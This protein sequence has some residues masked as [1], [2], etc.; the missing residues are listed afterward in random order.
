MVQAIMD[1]DYTNH[2]IEYQRAQFDRNAYTLG[3]IGRHN[4]VLVYMPGM[5]NTN[6][7]SVAADL[8]SSFQAIEIVFVVGICG[9]VSTNPE[10]KDELV[11]GDCIISTSVAQYD[12]ARLFPKGFEPKTG[13]DDILG[14]ASPLIRALIAKLKTNTNR[15]R[16]TRQLV[17][18]LCDLQT[19]RHGLAYPGAAQD[20]L[21]DS[22]YIHQ[23]HDSD[24]RCSECN[25]DMDTCKRDCEALGCD[26]IYLINRARL[27]GS[28]PSLLH[29]RIHFGTF[30][31]SNTLM[32]SG[33]D[34]DN[35]SEH[36]GIIAFEM[37]SAGIWDTFPTIIIK[38]GCDYADSH[39][40]KTWQNYA[41]ASAACMLKV[42]LHQLETWQDSPLPTNNIHF[43]VDN[44][45][46]EQQH[47][48]GMRGLKRMKYPGRSRT[49]DRSGRVASEGFPKSQVT[50]DPSGVSAY[51]MYMQRSMMDASRNLGKAKV[52]IEPRG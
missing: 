32:R 41:A 45:W 47:P 9:I 18:L 4:V 1:E 6:S 49:H 13:R 12:N 42:F 44:P 40:N 50:Q 48:F 16:L 36:S 23:H 22:T 37:E 21:F 52:L 30:G 35:L 19:K 24:L 33:L 46:V 10:T 38:A 51:D 29:P 39:K 34:R 3:L 25:Q 31:S 43:G 5:G 11:L 8:R 15:T 7:A 28:D 17:D 27:S 20:K 2:G 14:R 26:D